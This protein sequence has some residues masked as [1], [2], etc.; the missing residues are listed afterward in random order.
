MKK[1]LYFMHVPWGLIKQ[2]PHF[3]AEKLADLYKV[4]V[5]E[6]LSRDREAY[7]GFELR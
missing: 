6:D 4:D 1:I 7:A 3:L 2:R 5:W